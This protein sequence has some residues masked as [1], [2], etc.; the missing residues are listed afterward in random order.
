MAKSTLGG[1]PP[2]AMIHIKLAPG[3]APHSQV[4]REERRAK[5]MRD[6]ADVLVAEVLVLAAGDVD[7]SPLVKD[8]RDGGEL[9]QSRACL[10]PVNV[11]AGF[12]SVPALMGSCPTPTPALE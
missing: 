11:P 9:L 3:M 12:L 8:T 4:D 5:L 1:D 6:E 10:T 7:P 2:L